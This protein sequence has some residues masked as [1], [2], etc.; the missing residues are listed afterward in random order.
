[1][2]ATD[3]APVA[4]ITGGAQ[5]I[6]AAVARRLHEAGYRVLIHY[7]RSADSA[8]ALCSELNA[9]RPDSARALC[10]EMSDVTA[11]QALADQ[12]LAQWQRL[13]LLL[14]NASSFYPTPIGGATEADWE[15]LL[16]SNLKGPFFLSQALAPAL[17]ERGGSIINMVDIYAQRP[18]R[19][20]TVY[21]AAKAGL[22][23]LTQSLARELAPA[24]RVNG[25]APGAILW[26]EQEGDFSAQ[27]RDNILERVP[28]QRIGGP[29]DIARTVL[30][31]AD[32]PYITG[33]II[34]VDGGRSLSI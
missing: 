19:E 24:V 16:G 2:P 20:H 5:R 18:L 29:E 11:V 15:A 1:M 33:Q 9:R 28:L 17:T 34:A 7:R 21:C 6:G 30:F 23:M 22:A 13:D 31:L 27:E 8:R 14:N 10:A 26:P 3:S 32:S 4:L 12:A 25:I